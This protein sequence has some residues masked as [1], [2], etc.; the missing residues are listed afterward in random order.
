MEL[1]LEEDAYFDFITSQ[2]DTGAAVD[3]DS[4][5]TA[6]VFE[7]ATDTT[8]VALTVTKRTSK[9]GNYRVQVTAA[10]ASGFEAGKTYNVVASATVNSVVGKGIIG[11][12]KVRTRGTDDFVPQTG[13]AYAIV[14]SGTHGNAALKTLIDGL[15]ATVGVAG[16][17][18]TAT[19]TAVW[20]VAT[21]LLTAGTNIVLAK[22]TGVTGF[23]DL[24][25]AQVNDEADTALAD[26]DG[27]TN[28]ELATA[29]STADDA[30]LSAIA[31]LNNLSQANIRTA[32]GLATANLDTQL[33]ALPTNAELATALAAADDAILAAVAALNN[34]S[35]AQAQTAAAAALTAYDPPTKAE[36]DSAIAPLAL[37]ATSQSV[38][39]KTDNLPS[40]PA[41]QSLI[42]AATN[43]IVTLLGTPAGASLAADVAAV[44][45]KTGNLPSDPADQSA[46]EAAILNAWTT[47][48]TESYAAQGAPPT[49]AQ[50]LF[51]LLQRFTEFGITGTTIQ[52]LKLDRATP[53]YALTTDDADNPTESTRA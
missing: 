34:L 47:A 12:F 5:P 43:A 11:R 48:L 41:D 51:M 6:E 4:L 46:V 35:S 27:P 30:I 22:G 3:A 38:K 45:A 15:I 44:A 31:A 7:D 17:G 39:G 10:A 33:D 23:N 13:D 1:K 53:A 14:N 9:T 32:L 49:P 16:A 18:L 36:L 24:S 52:M 2:F 26:Y 40:D 42:I 19:A 28:A 29:L 20:A 50:F 21:R 25:A 8:V 37:E